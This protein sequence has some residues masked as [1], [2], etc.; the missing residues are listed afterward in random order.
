MK[1]VDVL[2]WICRKAISGATLGIVDVPEEGD[3][4]G[5]QN[6]EWW[7]A[8]FG[9]YPPSPIEAGNYLY[10]Y[11]SD[12]DEINDR[13]GNVMSPDAEIELPLEN[14]FDTIYLYKLED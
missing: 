10:Y 12:H 8:M 9:N 5:A 11:N 2:S 14:G 1:A 3:G 7:Y 6:E 4:W 13:N